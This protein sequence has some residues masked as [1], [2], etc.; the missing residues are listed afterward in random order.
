MRIATNDDPRAEHANWPTL[1]G[2]QRADCETW[3][4]SRWLG[5]HCTTRAFEAWH[6]SVPLAVGEEVVGLVG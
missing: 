6:E 3:C 1:M 2:V 4:P 5:E